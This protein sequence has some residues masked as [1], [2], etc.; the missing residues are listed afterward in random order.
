MTAG[1]TSGISSNLT[2]AKTATDR[3]F[4]TLCR[5]TTA[6]SVAVEI[7]AKHDGLLTETDRDPRLDAVFMS[8]IMLDYPEC[9]GRRIVK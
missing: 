4:L 7:S 5:Y 8:G 1:C 2:S 3:V 6:M 9:N